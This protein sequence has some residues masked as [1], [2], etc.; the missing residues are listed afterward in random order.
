MP[1]LFEQSI[2]TG[3]YRIARQPRTYSG[4]HA[5]PWI[6]IELAFSVPERALS[7]WALADALAEA[8]PGTGRMHPHAFLRYCIRQG[9]LERV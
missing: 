6:A 2:H 4:K 8:C 7:Y 9:W 1:L 3:H 5:A